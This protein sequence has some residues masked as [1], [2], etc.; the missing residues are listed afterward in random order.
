MAAPSFN[1]GGGNN[2]PI[3]TDAASVAK[4]KI[5]IES[6]SREDA[7]FFWQRLIDVPLYEL[8]DAAVDL[9]W[10]TQTPMDDD[11]DECSCVGDIL[12]LAYQIVYSRP[13]G[14]RTLERLMSDT[15]DE[16]EDRVLSSSSTGRP[17]TI[18]S[19]AAR[20]PG[21]GS[22]ITVVVPTASTHNDDNDEESSSSSSAK[23]RSRFDYSKFNLDVESSYSSSEEEDDD[24]I[25]APA[26][27]SSSKPA[28]SASTATM[29]TFRQ[30]IGKNYSMVKVANC[31]VADITRGVQ[32][33]NLA[34]DNQA[35][36]DTMVR[37][38]IYAFDD[39][40]HL[41]HFVQYSLGNQKSRQYAYHVPFVKFSG[42]CTYKFDG[43]MEQET[44][45]LKYNWP[46][47]RHEGKSRICVV[48]D[49]SDYAI[50]SKTKKVLKFFKSMGA[51]IIIANMVK[52]A[53]LYLMGFSS[54]VDA[55]GIM[56]T[57]N[58][59]DDG[60][61]RKNIVGLA[62]VRLGHVVSSDQC[63]FFDKHA[64]KTNARIKFRLVKSK[65]S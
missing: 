27:A 17:G 46:K 50:N 34:G 56:G 15:F 9:E 14:V 12:H 64:K 10:H 33:I 42:G 8:A 23:Q 20:E 16:L 47:F 4:M 45:T 43:D 48:I 31:K 36:L 51:V 49:R 2:L 63:V 26:R 5:P 13:R 25:T 54:L 18:Q 24:V 35:E 3:P 40:R 19:P 32:V 11:G 53:S 38:L 52:H 44:R 6:L 29:E 30:E 39:E 21:A 22:S 28:A 60:L 1:Q 57:T 37:S 7:D 55:C 58:H 41:T 65:D 61:H 59:C 62:Q